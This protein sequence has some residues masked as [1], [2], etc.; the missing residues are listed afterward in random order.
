MKN[1][2]SAKSYI[3][4]VSSR[5]IRSLRAEILMS[6]LTMEQ[7]GE[8]TGVDRQTVGRQIVNERMS[9]NSFLALAQAINADPT[10]LIADAITKEERA[11]ADTKALAK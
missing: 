9:L 6:D 5:A 7:I 8:K 11:S 4:K 10:S 2:A 1:I 3:G